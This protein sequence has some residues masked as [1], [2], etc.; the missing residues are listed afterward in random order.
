MTRREAT[1]PARRGKNR[2]LKRGCKLTGERVAG[3][4]RLARGSI[5][6]AQAQRAFPESG[7]PRL[8][9]GRSPPRLGMML[10]PGRSGGR[11]ARFS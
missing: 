10:G 3:T 2:S 11:L 4:A 9:P 5:A 8:I 6:Q 7:G 1:R